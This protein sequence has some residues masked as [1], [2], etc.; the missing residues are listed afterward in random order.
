V[1][2][3]L[4]T[5]PNLDQLKHQAKELLQAYYAGEDDARQLFERHLVSIVRPPNPSYAPRRVVLAHAL[6]VMAREYGFA[7][8]PKL[9]QHV[10]ALAL[11]QR[12]QA[13]TNNHDERKQLQRAA[14]RRIAQM[15]EHLVTAAR[16][17][18]FEQLF[19]A[20][21]VPAHDIMAMRAYLVEQDMYT[22]VIDALLLSVG[23]ANARIRFL[24]AQAM[25]HFADQRCA[26]PLRLL[27]RDPVPR[28][29]WAALHSLQCA[30]CKLAPLAA[31]GDVVA[32]IV[33]LALH[34][35]S[36]KVRRVATYELGQVCADP[37]ALAALEAIR[38]QATDRAIL[39]HVRHALE[40]HYL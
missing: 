21:C 2:R 4:P 36:I 22:A 19:A 15:A 24:G 11:E 7:S 28:V 29:R 17:Q 9:K 1:P 20:L 37:R 16:Q 13:Q 40:R 23:H 14:Q 33:D 31:G 27:L 32:T 3:L 35:P 38:A 26:E 25:D 5:R 39:R 34:D 8:W 10:E 30:E 18:Q 6:T 12:V